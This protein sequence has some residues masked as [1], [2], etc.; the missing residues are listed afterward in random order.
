MLLA[1]PRESQVTINF[2]GFWARGTPFCNPF[3][4]WEPRHV[5]GRIK[6]IAD[7]RIPIVDLQISNLKSQISNLKSQFAGLS[8][9]ILEVSQNCRLPNSDC[10]FS[11][12]KSKTENPKFRMLLGL[13]FLFCQPV[14]LSILVV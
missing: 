9:L 12:S 7:S 13:I 5:A 11:N 14:G 10:R 4:K 1:E 2:H 3:A 6:K 8:F